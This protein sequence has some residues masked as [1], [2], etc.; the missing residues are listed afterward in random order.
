MKKTYGLFTLLI[1]TT[2]SLKG[3]DQEELRL[4]IEALE[5]Q[6]ADLKQLLL[7]IEK[8]D[9]KQQSTDREP[10]LVSTPT[11]PST[12]PDPS[13]FRAYWKEGIRM[14]SGDQN[15]KLKMGG[16]IMNDW[17]A[18]SADDAI[19]DRFSPVGGTEFR[20]ARFYFSGTIHDRVEFKANYDFAGSDADFKDVW[21]GIK[22]IPTL[23][24]FKVGH[25][26]EPFGLEALNSSKYIP[27]MER[28][29]ASALIPFRNTG[30]M[31][32]NPLADERMTWAA[33]VFKDAP[34]SGLGI[35]SNNY[36][37]TG[38]LTGLPLYQNGGRRLVHLGMAYSRRNPILDTLR[39]RER[40]GTHLSA[41]WVNTDFFPARSEDLLGL[42]AALVEGPFSLQSEY[43][44]A[45]ANSPTL[46]DPSFNSFYVQGSFFLTGENRRYKKESGAFTRARPRGNLFGGEKGIGAW[47]LV[48]RYSRLD[49]DEGTI[50]GGELNN[51][52][53]GLNWYLNPNT[54]FM[55]N[56]VL[57]DR[58]DIGEADIFQTRFQID[59]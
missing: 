34:D 26:K 24:R 43:V 8:N 58:K 36:S 48:A 2:L 14:D 11:E 12:K 10:K 54:R 7:Q 56:Y 47:E 23:G 53:L 21:I 30:F 32:S 49:L 45:A 42:E 1:L 9:A 59:F 13:T 16:R 50:L 55:F 18:F 41:R 31:F 38:R 6:V 37:V 3:Q 57:A 22:G 39:F 52:T 4:R 33:G 5:Q 15:F 29:L 35:G 17:V 44:N 19:H 20:R 46:G 51:L 40:P 28:S 27:F 25:F